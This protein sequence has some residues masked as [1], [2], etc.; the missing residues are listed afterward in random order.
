MAG[1]KDSK[2]ID[3]YLHFFE[4]VRMTDA[5]VR[6]IFIDHKMK[7]RISSNS[8][9]VWHEEDTWRIKALPKKGHVQLFHNNYVKRKNGVRTRG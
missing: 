2:D 6:N 8:L 5:Q 9:I 7:T 4:K 3:L 1:A